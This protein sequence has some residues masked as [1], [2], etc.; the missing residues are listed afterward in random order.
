MS[1]RG[2]GESG[3]LLVEMAIS[4]VPPPLGTTPIASGLRSRVR[5][6]IASAS[7]LMAGAGG[8]GRMGGGDPY[9]PDLAHV[10]AKLQSTSR[11]QLT[12]EAIR[13]R[14]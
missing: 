3:D 12:T 11:T 6:V 10:F 2:S 9:R 4:V 5:R 14:G 8:A 13:H 7:W 1:A